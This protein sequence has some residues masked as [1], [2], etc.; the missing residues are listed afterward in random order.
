M[1]VEHSEFHKI[2]QVI[3]SA[4]KKQKTMWNSKASI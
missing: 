1:Y 4:L 3:Q 2:Q